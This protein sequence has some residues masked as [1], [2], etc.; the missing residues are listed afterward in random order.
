[1]K[2]NKKI[3]AVIALILI[4]VISVTATLL[5]LREPTQDND[6]STSTVTTTA[7]ATE[8]TTEEETESEITS[9]KVTTTVPTTKA[10]ANTSLTDSD[11]YNF[12]QLMAHVL[13]HG[14]EVSVDYETYD[15]K[16]SD[17]LKYAIS[18]VFS[19]AYHN[20][21]RFMDESLYGFGDYEIFSSEIYGY[22]EAEKDP[23]GLWDQYS[24]VSKEYVDMVF[25]HVFNVDPKDTD[26]F[27]DNNNNLIAYYQDELC[28]M[29]TED[30]G[31]GA[32][33]E[34]K[35]LDIEQKNDGRYEITAA[36]VEMDYKN[37]LN[38]YDDVK[39]TAEIKS[40]EGKRL[41]SI[42]KIEKAPKSGTKAA[43][44]SSGLKEGCYYQISNTPGAKGT[45]YYSLPVESA[46]QKSI[47]PEGSQVFVVSDGAS[48]KTGFVYCIFYAPES[49]E[50]IFGYLPKKYLEFY[51]DFGRIDF[52][53]YEHYVCYNTPSHDGVNLRSGPSAYSDLIIPLPEGSTV[54]LPS[55]IERSGEYIRVFYYNP[56][57]N[58][59]ETPELLVGWV[60]DKYI[61]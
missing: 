56:F 29:F 32:G 46:A 20:L 35:I 45:P 38:R 39:V 60:L 24:A 61:V 52:N 18:K 37:I 31:D 5:I 48:N 42:Y 57:I 7:E 40:I 27:Y 41:W 55:K 3:V 15:Y 2:I 19:P 16:S 25:R 4:F 23:K 28:Y 44:N 50:E 6:T 8:E 59:N 30:G 14:F 34:V 47:I 49:P 54:Y 9:Q 17:A 22:D 13:Y 53:I 43:E 51:E 36:F 11:M 21:L 12:E 10:P 1:M 26:I 58:G 33:P